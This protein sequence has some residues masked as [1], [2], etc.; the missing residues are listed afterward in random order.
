MR[1]LSY[2]MLF[3]NAVVDG[4]FFS[5][6]VKKESYR[7]KEVMLPFLLYA[8]WHMNRD[9]GFGLEYVITS[10][11]VFGNGCW[12]RWS[13]CIK[14]AGGPGRCEGN[15]IVL[16]VQYRPLHWRAHHYVGFEVWNTRFSLHFVSCA[17][18]S[19]VLTSVKYTTRHRCSCT[20]PRRRRWS[21][22][23]VKTK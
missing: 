6:P 16:S 14:R 12:G 23:V 20:I 22:D 10:F 9:P 18:S 4:F 19:Y 21:V 2:R 13:S 1:F 15:N 5:G 7:Y 3:R 17:I 11:T 8:E